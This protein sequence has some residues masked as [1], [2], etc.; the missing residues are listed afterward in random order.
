MQSTP[1]PTKKGDP[2]SHF[3]IGLNSEHSVRKV[4]SDYHQYHDLQLILLKLILITSLIKKMHYLGYC[5]HF[6]EKINFVS[7]GFL[8]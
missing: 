2:K 3:I 7:L 8:M 4:F 6:A 1:N 5:I